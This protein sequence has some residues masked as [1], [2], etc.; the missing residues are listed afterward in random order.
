MGQATNS[1]QNIIDFLL[2]ID[3]YIDV[4]NDEYLKGLLTFVNYNW[5]HVT[6]VQVQLS[7]IEKRCYVKND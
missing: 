4:T 6:K 3:Y 5:E 7:L 1:T 2:D